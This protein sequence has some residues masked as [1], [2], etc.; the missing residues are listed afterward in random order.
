MGINTVT[1]C[2]CVGVRI[3]GVNAVTTCF[4]HS[5][6][7]VLQVEFLEETNLCA[8]H[9]RRVT[10]MPRDMQLVRRIRGRTDAGSGEAR[11]RAPSGGVFSLG[12]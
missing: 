2:C 7:L 5:L 1:T 12:G 8:V 11:T 3:T 6:L 4:S 9:A 10:I